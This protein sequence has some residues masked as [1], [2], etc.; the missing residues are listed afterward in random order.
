MLSLAVD[1][2]AETLCEKRRPGSRP[3]RRTHAT[4]GLSSSDD[5]TSK[6]SSRI[7]G[8]SCCEV[9]R[10]TFQLL[11]I[12][13]QCCEREVGVDVGPGGFGDGL[14]VELF[15]LLVA[16]QRRETLNARKIAVQI[17]QKFVEAIDFEV[18]EILAE[19]L[20][21]RLD[22]RVRLLALADA[23]IDAVAEF[24]TGRGLPAGSP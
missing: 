18:L 1:R 2:R 13:P 22:M 4:L 24:D 9:D 14:V 7:N 23:P 12:L 8:L 15:A 21:E 5:E 6:P 20:S 10:A 3:K 16:R 19:T 11:A 17:G